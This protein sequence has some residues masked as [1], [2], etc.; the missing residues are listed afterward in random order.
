MKTKIAAIISMLIVG[1]F[2]TSAVAQEN[3]AAAQPF[4]ITLQVGGQINGGYDL[5]TLVFNRIEVSNSVN[6]GITTGYLMG[7]HFG[8]EFQWNRNSA[9]TTGQSGAFSSIKLFTL[10]QD[11]YM[12]N[13]VFHLTSR[14][15]RMRPFL[16]FGLGANSLDTNI[17]GVSG[18]T[19]FAYALGAGAKYNVSK[20]FGLRGQLRWAPTY[21]TTTNGGYWCDPVWGGCWVVGN[22]HY[23]HEFD[24][25]GGLTFRF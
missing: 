17:S 22:T 2:L 12:G 15:A 25:T 20:H 18:S 23:L 7:E 10:N 5:S 19:R 21:L 16:F 8:L 9:D 14:E 24:V 6:Y 11:Q 13:F 3:S 4:E 1:S